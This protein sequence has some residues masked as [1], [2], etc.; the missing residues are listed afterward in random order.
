MVFIEIK[1]KNEIKILD[2]VNKS[3]TYLDP[4][5]KKLLKGENIFK[6]QDII[7]LLVDLININKEKNT[8]IKRALISNSI[9]QY[10]NNKGTSILDFKTHLT[11]ESN[12]YYSKPLKK[13]IIIFP[14]NIDNNWFTRK[15][16]TLNGNT[17]LVRDLSY[18]NKQ[19]IAKNPSF[20]KQQ[21]EISQAFHYDFTYFIISV[22]ARD[23]EIALRTGNKTCELLRAIINFGTKLGS[24]SMFP[25]GEPE[26]DYG[27][28]SIM[29]IFDDKKKYVTHYNRP[30]H[31]KHERARS[32]ISDK[33]IRLKNISTFLRMYESLNEKNKKMLSQA[34]WLYN[35]ALDKVEYSLMF[36]SLWQIIEYTVRYSSNDKFNKIKR[37]EK[38]LFKDSEI[39]S[40]TIDIFQ[41]KRNRF[42]HYGDF[43]AIEFEDTSRIK[44]L[45]DALLIFLF[46]DLKEF[47]SKRHMIYY[48][49]NL[50]LKE[51]DIDDYVSILTRIKDHK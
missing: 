13:F 5:P 51:N 34:L 26:T 44:R 10:R 12:N 42:V 38:N 30:V 17:I 37:R 27:P 48:L 32:P 1:P 3:I 49:D 23:Y 16:I 4:Q 24:F 2:F 25:S 20:L 45:V 9:V 35:F 15:R 47:K 40:P 7:Y 14:M 28:S 50:N 21:P 11:N 19:Y 8:R 22:S 43:D 18:V 29:P 46:Y 6:F 39:V 36:L 41:K 33:K 31:K